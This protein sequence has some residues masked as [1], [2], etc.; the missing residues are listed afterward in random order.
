VKRRAFV[1]A[2]LALVGCGSARSTS[3]DR[4]GRVINPGA[5]I[6]IRLLPLAAIQADSP[7]MSLGARTL[8]KIDGTF[9]VQLP[10]DA[11][12]ADLVRLA[13]HEVMVHVSGWTQPGAVTS[14]NFEILRALAGDGFDPRA[15]GRRI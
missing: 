6:V 3:T 13:L 4:V 9:E 5:R 14:A 12:P 11:P 8:S 10:E 15:C 2:L 1:A 7:G